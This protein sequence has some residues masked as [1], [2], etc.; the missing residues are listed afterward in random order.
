MDGCIFIT[1]R[2]AP[3]VAH[4]RRV[5]GHAGMKLQVLGCAGGIGGRERFTTCLLVDDDILL[6]AGTGL[7]HLPLD[8]LL[9]IDHVFVTH[10]HLDHVAGL[11]FLLDA[12]QGKR[13]APVAV[14]AT[15]NVIAA[16]KKHLFNWVLWPDFAAIPDAQNA[17]LRW[18]SLET[19]DALALGDRRISSMAV[20]HTVGSAAYLVRNDADGFLFTG[21]MASTPA[22]WAALANEQRPS[23]VIVDCSFVNDDSRLAELSLH[24]CPRALLVDIA[25]VDPAIE[26]LIYHLKPG[27]EERILREL[28]ADGGGRRFTALACGDAFVF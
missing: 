5:V 14:H 13:S 15:G 2:A 24:F 4:R 26:F 21:D 9:R 7:T 23:K 6:D 20:N 3:S 17:I 16:L 22:L 11:A 28:A 27:H 19:G 10:A 12:V 1:A 25:D 8:R 18:Q